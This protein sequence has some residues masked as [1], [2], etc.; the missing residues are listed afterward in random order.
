MVFLPFG[1]SASRRCC[2]RLPV[3]L[4][5]SA[6]ARLGWLGAGGPAGGAGAGLSAKS[7]VIL[8]ASVQRLVYS[9]R[10]ATSCA[11]RS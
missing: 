7:V 9:L 10:T 5:H 2:C 3:C 8:A 1:L 4:V 6:R 11:H